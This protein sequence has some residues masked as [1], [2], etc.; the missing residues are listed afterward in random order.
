MGSLFKETSWGKDNSQVI[1]EEG[2]LMAYNNLCRAFVNTA[3]KPCVCLLCAASSAIKRAQLLLRTRT[4]LLII[5]KN[6]KRQLNNRICSSTPSARQW[7]GSAWTWQCS[8]QPRMHRGAYYASARRPVYPPANVNTCV[9]YR[10]VCKNTLCQN[11]FGG[12]FLW[13]DSD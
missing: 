9:D 11:Q 4:I 3:S 5:I 13:L 2:K 12:V 7:R 6:N 1:I 8:K 10:P